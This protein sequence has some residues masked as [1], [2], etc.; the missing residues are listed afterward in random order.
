[1]SVV[2]G[3]CTIVERNLEPSYDSDG[4]S[5]MT[6]LVRTLRLRDLILLIIGS[7]IGSG[8]FMVPGT[9]LR[10]V[11][12]SVSVASLVWIAGGCSRCLEP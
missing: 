2:G 1:V 4:F 12:G 11:D 5:P 10:E 7:V 9:I 6:Q 3:Y 8:I